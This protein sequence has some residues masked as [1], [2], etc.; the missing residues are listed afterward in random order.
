MRLFILTV[1]SFTA[2]LCVAQEQ[3]YNDKVLFPISVREKH[4]AINRTG[5]VV[6]P[7]EYDETVVMREGLA[8]VRKGSRVAYLDAS[9]RRV[10]EP[11]DS[12][13]A[14]FSQGLAPA[15]GADEKGR[16]AWGY[17]DRTGRWAIPPRFADAKDFSGSRAAVGV[18]DEWGQ[19]KYGYIDAKGAL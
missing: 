7:P 18:A 14:L 3:S 17:I 13:E 2:M 9:G 15:R 12:T 19:V 4:G 11:Q 1:L 8:R 16:P 6:I 5:E 10:I